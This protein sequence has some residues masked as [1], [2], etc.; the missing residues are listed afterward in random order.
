[1]WEEALV[2]FHTL[3]FVF[4]LSE[5]GSCCRICTH[6]NTDAGSNGSRNDKP[7]DRETG[8]EASTT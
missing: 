6:N 2:G 8:Q 1:L 4:T 7:E 3:V 5:S